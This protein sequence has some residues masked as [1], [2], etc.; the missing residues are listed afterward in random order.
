MAKRIMLLPIQDKTLIPQQRA[1]SFDS[2]NNT[3]GEGESPPN[4]ESFL[5][6]LPR[7]IRSKGSL[8]LG[9]LKDYIK[10]DSNGRI[11]YD[12]GTWGSSIYD[13]VRYFCGN[14]GKEGTP[15]PV[16]FN[17]FVKLMH[18]AGVPKAALAKDKRYVLDGL[19]ESQTEDN[20]RVWKKLF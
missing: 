18:K 4:L 12:D 20:T 11:K 19:V 15:R 2:V 1:S 3:N 17:E 6:L 5:N 10:V 7:N 13:H 16:D 8:L 14:A 9:V